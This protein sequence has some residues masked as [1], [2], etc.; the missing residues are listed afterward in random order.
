MCNMIFLFKIVGLLILLSTPRTS[1]SFIS[2]ADFPPPQ[3]QGCFSTVAGTI[4]APSVLCYDRKSVCK[5][6]VISGCGSTCWKTSSDI[7]QPFIQICNSYFIWISNRSSLILHFN[8]KQRRQK[9]NCDSRVLCTKLIWFH[10]IVLQK[11]SY[12]LN[13]WLKSQSLLCFCGILRYS[14]DWHKVACKKKSKH[15]LDFLV[16]KEI[17]KFGVFAFNS[18][19]SEVNKT[20]HNCILKSLN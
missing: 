7:I 1:K 19:Y 13:L 12:S 11:Y 16:Q 4:K 20:Q 9:A 3:R 2:G 10:T 15:V 14:L 6:K 18:L 5:S 8:S 17:W